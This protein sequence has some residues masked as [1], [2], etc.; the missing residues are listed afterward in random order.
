MRTHLSPKYELRSRRELGE[1]QL[2]SG[3]SKSSHSSLPLRPCELNNKLFSVHLILKQVAPNQVGGWGGEVLFTFAVV[4]NRMYSTLVLE[5]T[6][7]LLLCKFQDELLFRQQQVYTWEWVGIF[8]VL[9]VF[10]CT[11][12]CY[13]SQQPLLFPIKL[14]RELPGR[15]CFVSFYPQ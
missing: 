9:L 8:S 5:L 2:L 13:P 1:I 4:F 10:K 7:N 3:T 11:L 6:L 15:K 12:R 14:I